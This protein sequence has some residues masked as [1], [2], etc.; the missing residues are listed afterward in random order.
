MFGGDIM[1]YAYLG[2]PGTFC[3]M[4][5]LKYC[6]KK[7]KKI[8]FSTVEEIAKKVN[9]NKIERGVLPLENSLEGAVNNTHSVLLEM[10]NIQVIAEIVIPIVHNLLAVPGMKITDITKVLSHPMAI[11]QSGTFIRNHLSDKDIVYTN[12]TARAAE[13]VNEN[14]NYAMIGS[15]R[16]GEKYGLEILVHDIQ[17]Y[18]NN[19]TR[20]FV[21]THNSRKFPQKEGDYKT[22]IIC[23]PKVN[24]PGVLCTILAE[25]ADRGIDLTRIESR[26]TKKK[27]GEYIFYIDIAGHSEENKTGEALANVECI[28]RVFKNLG[29]YQK[30]Y[31]QER[32]GE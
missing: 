28:S 12:S 6:D 20:F 10:E 21:I 2:P 7:D 14:K 13:I 26:P 5:L 25:F 23:T 22:S 3:E 19:Y 30:Y 4:A 18:A 11:K 32:R 1:D 8:P 31:F 29:S 15:S 24:K 17:D 27:L 9:D 16:S